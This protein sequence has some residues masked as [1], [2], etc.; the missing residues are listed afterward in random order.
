M[1]SGLFSYAFMFGFSVLLEYPLR[2]TQ[3]SLEANVSALQEHIDPNIEDPTSLQFQ[4]ALDCGWSSESAVSTL[5]LARQA[6]CCTTMVEQGH[7]VGTLTLSE[8]QLASV[9]NMQARSQIHQSRGCFEETP[10][11][12]RIRHIEDKIERLEAE[13]NKRYGPLEH[14]ASLVIAAQQGWYEC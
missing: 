5:A 2:L 10:D 12:R 1:Y 9:T 8:T 7:A 14:V 3:G 4:R 13:L 6:C 11:A